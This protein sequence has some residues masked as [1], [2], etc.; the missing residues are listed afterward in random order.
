MKLQKI[1][2]FILDPIANNVA[3]HGV[4]SPIVSLTFLKTSCKAF[5]TERSMY[6]H[7]DKLYEVK[8]KTS[9][10]ICNIYHKLSDKNAQNVSGL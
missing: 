5:A 1:S 8:D 2:V 4:T 3:R 9:Y 6:H 7:N 10:L